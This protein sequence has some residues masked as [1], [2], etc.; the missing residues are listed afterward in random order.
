MI[1]V[2]DPP[3][4]L[5]SGSATR[6]A[7]LAAAG[8]VFTTATPNV[9]ERAVKQ[10]ARAEGADAGEAALVLA[11]TKAR[12]VRTRGTLVIGADQILVHRGDWLDKPADMAEARSH[13]ERL[14][15]SRHELA[16]AV[17]CLRDGVCLW[18]HIAWPA[19]AMRAFSD[20]FLDAYLAAEGAACLTS[21]GAFRLEG[22]G[23]HLFSQIDGEHSAI[24]G[25]PM[26]PLLNFLRQYGIL[27][28]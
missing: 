8:L 5:A 22:L 23:M 16:T 7:L 11:E 17:V 9:D 1:Q 28:G 2:R 10:E 3:L 27:L 21:V 18:R 4:V 25:L 12:R 6:A 15:D 24:L 13:L 19:L 14:R 20:S 26:L